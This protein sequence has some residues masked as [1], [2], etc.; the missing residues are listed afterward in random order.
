MEGWRQISQPPGTRIKR[1]GCA[2]CH[3]TG[4]G[5]IC[6]DFLNR[7]GMGRQSEVVRSVTVET[8]VMIYS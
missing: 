6:F 5:T 4:V 7:K 2:M 3:L 1:R 8:R